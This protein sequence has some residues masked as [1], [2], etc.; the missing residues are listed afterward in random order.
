MLL[1]AF[2]EQADVF[3][4]A[5]KE[6]GFFARTGDALSY[7]PTTATKLGEQFTGLFSPDG[8]VRQWLHN[9]TE[10]VEDWRSDESKLRQFI[11]ARKMA[12]AKANGE[13]G[14]TQFFAN[15]AENPLETVGQFAESALPTVVATGAGVAAAPITG[16]ASLAL[17]FLV[18]GVQGA[19]ELVIIFTTILWQ[20]QKNNY[21]KIHNIRRY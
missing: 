10:A 12:E 9:A 17:P 2:D 18:G 15:A 4:K 16:G 5:D 20:C 3:K 14:F 6:A 19:G 8:E 13:S 11:A 7:I 21:P 1:S